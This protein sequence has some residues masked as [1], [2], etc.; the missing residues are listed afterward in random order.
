M[1]AQNHIRYHR[2]ADV[3]VEEVA[4]QVSHMTLDAAVG[5]AE[6][7]G[8]TSIR[9]IVVVAREAEAATLT[10]CLAPVQVHA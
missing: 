8:H 2:I 3:V 5:V 9:D 6:A 1:E 4:Y 7:A 10:S